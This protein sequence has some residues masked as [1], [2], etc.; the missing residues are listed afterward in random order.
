[1]R[2]T[3]LVT[4]LVFLLRASGA[5]S[6]GSLE[7][8]CI[9]V[10]VGDST[11]VLAPNGNCILIDSG[12]GTRQ[13]EDAIVGLV[14]ALDRQGKLRAR[15][16]KIPLFVVS[17]YDNDHIGG[18]KRVFSRLATPTI[19]YDIGA[20]T[21]TTSR[22]YENYV[23]VTRRTTRRELVPGKRLPLG[24][25][26]EA[27]CLVVNGC[28]KSDRGVSPGYEAASDNWR[29]SGFLITYGRFK[30]F[31]AGDLTGASG[32]PEV[33]QRVAP[34]AGDVD[35]YHVDHHGSST[36]S[37]DEFLETLKPE[38]AVISV[39]S[40]RGYKHPRREVLERL[41]ERGVQR[42]FTTGP[43]YEENVAGFEQVVTKDSNV[44]VVS[45]GVTYSIDC[46]DL[47]FSESPNSDGIV[48]MAA[49]GTP[50]ILGGTVGAMGVSGSKS[51]HV[52]G[53]CRLL[54][55]SESLEPFATP[56]DAESRSRRLCPL[57]RRRIVPA[58]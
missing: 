30:Y 44:R 23:E 14:E 31:T 32:E 58:D 3:L 11:L 16:P 17:H 38:Y 37:A 53:D 50:P 47:P 56:S 4:I 9:N 10:G 21:E 49:P 33:E 7:I 18:V 40:H 55:T 42:I 27:R 22:D 2:L 15:Q 34:V 45:N 5:T 52:F 35:V 26:V 43:G 6:A 12:K 54:A 29:C 51:Y 24:A 1:M 8:Y 48:A 19:F 41:Q 25:G 46:D 39:K 36:S 57:C 20:E 13:A 28:I